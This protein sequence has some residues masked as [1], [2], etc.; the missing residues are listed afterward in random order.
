MEKKK[1]PLQTTLLRI[2]IAKAMHRNSTHQT[3]EI[4]T[5]FSQTQIR[6]ATVGM[7]LSTSA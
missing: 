6:D 2:D 4:S 1:Y 3:G 7:E 5:H